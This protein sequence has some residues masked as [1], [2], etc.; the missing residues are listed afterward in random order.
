MEF[1]LGQCPGI[2][3]SAEWSKFQWKRRLGRWVWP[4][5]SR[6]ASPVRQL[7]RRT[8]RSGSGGGSTPAAHAAAQV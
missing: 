5:M 7:L 2:R 3:A 4:V 1:A 8:E 6:I